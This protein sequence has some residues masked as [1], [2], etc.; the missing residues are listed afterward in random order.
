MANGIDGAVVTLQSASAVA[1]SGTIM[2]VGLLGSVMLE[3]TGTFTGLLLFP[4]LSVGGTTYNAAKVKNIGTGEVFRASD[5]IVATGTYSV[6]VAGATLLR[7]RIASIATGTVSVQGIGTQ[8][9]PTE[10]ILGETPATKSKQRNLGA[11]VQIKSTPGAIKAIHVENTQAATAA[12][13]QV[14]DALNANITLGTTTPDLEKLVAAVSSADFVIPTDG[15]DFTT[16]IAIA[17]TTA[18]GGGSTSAAGV[19]CWVQYD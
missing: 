7:A 8:A 18:E 14:F 11:L 17:S 2:N 1:A 10:I 19:M 9:S 15:I 16:A 13:I 4:E 6:S 5:G 12:W 3:V